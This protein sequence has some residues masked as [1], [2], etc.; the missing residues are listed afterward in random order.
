MKQELTPEELELTTVVRD[1]WINLAFEGC[2]KGIDTEKFE[3]GIEWL[4]QKFLNLPKPQVIYCDSLLAA[5]LMITLIKD[6]GKEPEDYTPEV[7]QNYRDGKMDKQFLDQL[8]D[9]LK[10]KS[11]Y[12]GWSNMGWVAFYDFFTQINVLDNEDFNNYQ[13]LIESNVFECF[14]FDNVVFAVRPPIEVHYNET[15]VPHNV[16]G[17]SVLFQDGEKFYHINGFSTTPELFNKLYNR[18]YTFEDFVKESNEEVKSA[19][20]AY[21]QSRDGDTGVYYFLKQNLKEVD[22]FVDKKAEEFMEG[23]TRGMNIG[24]YTL[25]KGNVSDVDIAYVRCY[26]PSTDRM[27]FLGVEPEQRNAKDAIASLYTV[28]RL[29]KDKIVSISRQGEKFSTV[30]TEDVMTGLKNGTY[31]TEELQDYVSISGDEYFGKMRYEY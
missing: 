28:P 8:Q 4:Y 10:L 29:F 21:I 14:E 1:K 9:N 2:K 11:S 3:T 15:N 16:E 19:V 23:T 12:I 27:F 7:L 18:E 24:V 20:L 22:T 17:P 6:H 13:K 30:F 26:C 31:S 5:G 25:F